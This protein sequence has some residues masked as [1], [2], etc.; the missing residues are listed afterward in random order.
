MQTAV[1]TAIDMNVG[2]IEVQLPTG[3]KTYWVDPKSQLRNY[4]AG[5]RVTIQVQQ[6]G[7]KEVVTAMSRTR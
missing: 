2:Q 3:R 1:I 7:D 4:K 6:Q 5:D